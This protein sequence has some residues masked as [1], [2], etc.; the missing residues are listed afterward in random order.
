MTRNTFVLKIQRVLCH[1]KS[2]GTYEKQ[3][4]G[5]CFSKVPKLFGPVSEATIPF[6]SSQCWVLNHQRSQSS[7]CY[8]YIKNML[9]DQLFKT[10]GLLF[11]NWLFGP[12]KFSGLSRNRPLVRT[13][14]VLSGTKL[15]YITLSSSIINQ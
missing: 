1:P 13:Y 3:A 8:T 9:K 11:E 10:S 15:D 4:P 7:L 2:F 6:I 12:E 5:A 14:C